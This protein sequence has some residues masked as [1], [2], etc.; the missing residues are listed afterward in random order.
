MSEHQPSQTGINLAIKLGL[1]VENERD[2]AVFRW[3]VEQVDYEQIKTAVAQLQTQGQRRLYPAN[4]A[5]ALGLQAP[6]ILNFVATVQIPTRADLVD[7]VVKLKQES[8]G[9]SQRKVAYLAQQ[10]EAKLAEAASA[11]AEFL[12][13]ANAT[14]S[15]ARRGGS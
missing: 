3:V 4:I 1:L 15:R 13:R 12:V 5:R 7:A 2:A 8:R 14:I 11:Q 9:E 10:R 6:K